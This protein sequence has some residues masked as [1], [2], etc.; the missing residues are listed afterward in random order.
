MM[1]LT[2]DGVMNVVERLDTISTSEAWI[3]FGIAF[4]MIGLGM[5][6]RKIFERHC[7]KAA[8]KADWDEVLMEVYE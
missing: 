3:L 5:L 6:T 4:L 8:K 2:F 1:E 7:D